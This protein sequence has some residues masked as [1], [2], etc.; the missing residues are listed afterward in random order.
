MNSK[1]IWLL[2]APISMCLLIATSAN[3]QRDPPIVESYLSSTSVRRVDNGL[4]WTL[5]YT[6]TGGQTKAAY[7]YYVI[8]Y[9]DRHRKQITELTPQEAIAK[10]FG[11]ILESK[12]ANRGKDGRYNFEFT[13]ETSEFVKKMKGE[14]Q[15][16]DDR[17]SNLGGWK[18][19][20]DQI[21]LAIFIPFLDDQKY[22]VLEGLPQDKNDA[23]YRGDSALLFEAVTQRLQICFGIVQASRIKEGQFYLQL[24]G[25]RPASKD[26]R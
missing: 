26:A 24:N 17:T 22:S 5:S 9:S 18:S 16:A 10:K 21:R 8:A 3:A 19:F 1:C 2:A 13:I 7:Q 4:K 25:N 14:D 11:T 15:I 12:I 23:N 20:D 6:K